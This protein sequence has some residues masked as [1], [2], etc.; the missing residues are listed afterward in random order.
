MK[1]DWE[2]KINEIFMRYSGID[3]IANQDDMDKKLMGIELGIAPRTLVY[4]YCK[5]EEE[6]GVSIPVKEVVDGKFDTF[7]NICNV[8]VK[9]Q[10]NENFNRA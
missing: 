8:V 9:N 7:S 6:L 4:I 5:I 2:K 1:K 3:F 10:D